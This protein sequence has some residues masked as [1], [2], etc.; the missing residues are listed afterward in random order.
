MGG[1]RLT[2]VTAT[3]LARFSA[4]RLQEEVIQIAD[5]IFIHEEAPNDVAIVKIVRGQFY[6][7]FSP[8]KRPSR[9]EN[10]VAYPI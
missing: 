3:R 10:C 6:F 1:E 7:C 4:L 5:V 9:L 8:K 2:V